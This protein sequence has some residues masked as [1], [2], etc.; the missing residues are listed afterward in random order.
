M[1]EPKVVAQLMDD[2]SDRKAA[3]DP[4]NRP[5]DS[6]APN[7]HAARRARPGKDDVVIA[8]EA[9]SILCRECIGLDRPVV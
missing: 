5:W 4:R 9:D 2:R 6:G 3:V 1:K 8:A 7:P